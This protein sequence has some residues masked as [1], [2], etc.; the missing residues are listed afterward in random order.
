M[1]VPL[2]APDFRPDLDEFR[3]AVSDRTRVILLNT[4]H[5]PTGIV[6]DREFLE[7]AVELAHRHDAII[8]TDEV[9]EHLT[10]GVEHVPIATLPGRA[11]AH[12]HDLERRQDLQHHRLEGRLD[13]H[14]PRAARPRSS[15]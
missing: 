11:R 4:P 13:H 15:P 3:A 9:Y 6:L 12:G 8:V 10:F 1:T 14:D 2:R 5:N 7:L